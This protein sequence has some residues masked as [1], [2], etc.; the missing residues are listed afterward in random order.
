MSPKS[1]KLLRLQLG[2]SRKVRKTMCPD[3]L[4]TLKAQLKQ[5]EQELA[6][7][8][9]TW[10]AEEE[11]KAVEVIRTNPS[12]FYSYA[13]RFSRDSSKIGPLV[14]GEKDPEADPLEM[15]QILGRQY[16]SV[17]REPRTQ[18]MISSWNG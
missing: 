9:E 10:R 12:H 15:A 7:K 4:N 18:L 13:R 14:E 2:L 11:R 8:R 3:R 16:R 1:R 6:R 5:V 17:L